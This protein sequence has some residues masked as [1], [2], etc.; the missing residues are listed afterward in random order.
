AIAGEEVR[1]PRD[2]VGKDEAEEVLE[3]SDQLVAF[4]GDDRHVPEAQR[5]CPGLLEAGSRGR[6]RAVEL[7]SDAAWGLNFD[8]LGN[9]GLAVGLDG[10]GE[11]EFACVSGE[12]AHRDMGLQVK[13]YMQ[14]RLLI[15][16]AQNEIVVVVS[17]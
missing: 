16:R 6:N 2:V 15:A 5:R 7:D 14:Q 11:A 13:A 17:D 10:R 12:I 4:G 3:E 9:A 1:D 8:Q